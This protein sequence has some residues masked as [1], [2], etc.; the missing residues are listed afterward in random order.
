MLCDPQ[1]LT[2]RDTK[3]AYITVM[4]SNEGHHPLFCQRYPT[5]TCVAGNG[6]VRSSWN[7]V[8]SSTIWV[9]VT[10]SDNDDPLI[11][12][13]PSTSNLLGRG[14]SLSISATDLF[15]DRFEFN[16]NSELKDNGTWVSGVPL[17]YEVDALGL[18]VGDNDLEM[19]FFDLAGNT[20]SYSWSHTLL[21][22]DP[23]SR[24]TS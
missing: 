14:E 23:P 17:V 16:I 22:I 7:N 5:R 20:L 19:I 15:P 12:D 21:D 6:E 2:M 13:L 1:H 9:E 10:A 18:D 11:A 24:R 8:A 3:V 4:T